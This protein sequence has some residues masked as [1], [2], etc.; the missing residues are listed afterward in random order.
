[1]F[2]PTNNPY[3]FQYLITGITGPGIEQVYL[4]EPPAPD[5]IAFKE[6][7]RF[8]RPVMPAQ[9]KKWAREWRSQLKKNPDYVH[10][11]HEQIVAWENQQIDRCRPG[12]PGFWFYNAYDDD[13]T[14][15][16]ELVWITP[17]HYWLLTEWNPYF[18]VPDFRDS[19]REICYWIQYLEEDP[20]C[21]GGLFN[22]IRRYAKST[23]MGAWIVWRTTLS[24]RHNSGMQGETDKKIAKFYKKMV[25]KPFYKLNYYMQPTYN[26]STQQAS[27]IEFD[28]PAQRSEKRASIETEEHEVLE[29]MIDFRASSEGEY[30][31]EILNS[32]V[33]EEPG[34][35]KKVSLYNDDGEGLWDIIKP[36]FMQGDE[37]CGKALFGTTVE[38]MTISDKG[39]RAYKKI[40]YDSDFN[41]RQEDGRTKSGLYTA[42]LPG[43][44]GLKGNFD[45]NGRPKRDQARAS[46][47]RSRSSF[48]NNPRK[49]AGYIRKYPLTISEVFYV[50]PDRCEFN[51]TILQDRLREL[52][53]LK[54]PITNRYDLFWENNKRFSRVK[55]RHNPTGGWMEASWIPATEKEQNMVGEKYF[56]KANHYYPLN[57]ARLV[58]GMDPIQFGSTG[59]S[60]ESRPVQFIKKR[61]D[62]K[63]DGPMGGEDE[64]KKRAEE[65]FPYQSNVYVAMMHERPTNPNVLAE[66]SLLMCWFYGVSLHIEKQ[67]GAVHI[68][69]F[70]DNNCEDFILHKYKPDFEKPPST[71][72]EG[73]PASTGFTQ[74]YTGEIANY[75]DYFGH[76]IPF[77][78]QIEDMLIFDAN[79]TKEHDY[80]VATGMTETSQRMKAKNDQRPILDLSEIMPNFGH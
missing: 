65:R 73:T 62:Y 30:D 71:P 11:Q 6:E 60:R 53:T 46:M 52:D 43:D 74:Q 38:N 35:H 80:T 36:C 77:R 37:I 58:S 14:K 50:S 23:I 32:Y 42:F 16:P 1:M 55:W 64:L 54:V 4:P 7:K 63:V 45:V 48:K 26:T 25:L 20:D 49:L 17:F 39:G 66:R 72:T 19:D 57:D 47:M 31:G 5:K 18:G 40:F 68:A 70:W 44:C 2:K 56:N 41:D 59:S 28:L 69:Y 3:K 10:A 76:T 61:Y 27:S 78:A 33:G 15:E 79:N 24:F 9:I 22:T 21:F 67:A 75:V 29:S 8:V 34:K 51:A 13:S 12:G